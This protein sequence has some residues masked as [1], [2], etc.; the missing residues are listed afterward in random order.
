MERIVI[1]DLYPT[2]TET[3]I[4]DL[5]PKEL[6]IILGGIFWRNNPNWGLNPNI[7]INTVYDGI[8][9]VSTTYE[10]GNNFRDNK[11]NTVDY[12]RTANIRIY[13]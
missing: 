3:F 8:N 11:I 10:G 13:R 12:S 7:L 5:E 9:T 4:D 2:H 1:Y 6:N